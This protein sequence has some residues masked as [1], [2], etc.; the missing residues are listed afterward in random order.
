LQIDH[1][2]L[3]IVVDHKAEV[4]VSDHQIA[5]FET[6]FMGLLERSLDGRTASGSLQHFFDQQSSGPIRTQGFE[7]SA[8]ADPDEN[9]M[10]IDS[11]PSPSATLIEGTQDTRFARL[12]TRR[13]TSPIVELLAIGGHED[14]TLWNHAILNGD[15]AHRN[16]STFYGWSV[17]NEPRR[18]GHESRIQRVIA[19][20]L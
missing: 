17:G 5:G 11:Q 9:S 6:V 2:V 8:V 7:N 12:N 20:P 3:L 18:N 10:L 13:V 15:Q 14:R 19:G 1:F 4:S 16:I